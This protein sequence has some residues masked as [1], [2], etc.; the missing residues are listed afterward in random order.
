MRLFMGGLTKE[1]APSGGGLDIRR[2]KGKA[3][4]FC[5]LELLFH[6]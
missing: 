3:F 2:F 5:L 1:E 6:R 4:D